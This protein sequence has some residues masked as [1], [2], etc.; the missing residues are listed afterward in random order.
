MNNL[1]RFEKPLILIVEDEFILARDLVRILNGAG[2]ECIAYV[3]T[4]KEAIEIIN[5]KKLSLVIIDIILRKSNDGLLIG[6]YLYSME[7]L[8]YIY[9]TSLY[10]SS[11]IQEIQQTFPYG[12]IVKPFK[13]IDVITTVGLALNNFKFRKI[14]LNRVSAPKVNDNVPIQIKRVVLYIHEH[15]TEK[16]QIADLI[17]LTPWKKHN[18]IN[19]FTEYIGIT[20][21]QFIIKCKIE[22]CIVL[23]ENTD[24]TLNAIS[25]ELGFSSYSNFSKLFKHQTGD[26]LEVYRKKLKLKRS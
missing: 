15:I 24:L 23:M 1:E 4:F 25:Y 7:K 8:P 5:Q 12:Y 6:K 14:D 3:A 19:I 21:Y 18:F 9:I 11:T 20:P 26:T 16:I 22:K 2:F 13:P 17:N 10:D